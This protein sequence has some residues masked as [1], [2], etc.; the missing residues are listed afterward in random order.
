DRNQWLAA[1]QRP[2]TVI[3]GLRDIG[4]LPSEHIPGQRGKNRLSIGRRWVQAMASFAETNG[5]E[6]QFNFEI[7]PGQG[8]G[9]SG[10]MEYSEAALISQ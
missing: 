7:V 3:V 9:M 10:L 2:V 1:T 5:L 6:S 4:E 8:H